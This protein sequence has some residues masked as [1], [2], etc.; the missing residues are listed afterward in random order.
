MIAVCI[1]VTTGVRVLAFALLATVI[2]GAG[3]GGAGGSGAYR[4]AADRQRGG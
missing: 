2:R 4:R 1:S 3:A